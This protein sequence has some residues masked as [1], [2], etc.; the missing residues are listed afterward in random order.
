MIEIW[1]YNSET[2]LA[3]PVLIE[4][5]CNQV[6]QY[7]G[8]TGM[9]PADFVH[10]VEDIAERN[11]FLKEL[12]ILGGDHLGPSPW[13]GEPAAMA[14]SKAAEMVHLYVC[15]GFTKIHLDASMRLA[16]DLPGLLAPEVSARR[17]AELASAV[18]E[19]ISDNAA[20]PRYVI[21][22]EVPLAGGARDHE[23]GVD[24]TTVKECPAHT[25]GH[26]RR[27]CRSWVGVSLGTRYCNGRPA[28][29]RVRG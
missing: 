19:M 10:F 12:L 14:M 9:K 25:G 16:D 26:A 13:Q 8:Y 21:G 20:A 5:T 15:A 22:T 28:G 6:N 18:E 1:A 29:S 23:D 24:V 3:G 7:G 27:V 2:I 4:S 17:T 11:G